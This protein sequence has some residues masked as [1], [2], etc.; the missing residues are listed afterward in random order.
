[1]HPK[2]NPIPFANNEHEDGFDDSKT[3]V[4]ETEV[5]TDH[6][7]GHPVEKLRVPLVQLLDHLYVPGEVKDAHNPPLLSLLVVLHRR[8]KHVHNRLNLY[9]QITTQR[10]TNQNES[11]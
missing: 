4:V 8:E 2:P 5:A 1:M 9:A 11:N 7:D 10:K 6:L 3:R